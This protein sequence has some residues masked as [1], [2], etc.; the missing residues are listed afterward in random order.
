VAAVIVEPVVGNM[1]TVAPAP[2][3]LQ[4][5]RDL[6]AAAGS[7][8]IFDEVIT[9]FRT[10][11]GGAQRRFGV[12]PDLT[13][14]GKIV[15]GGLP[16]AAVAGPRVIMERLAPIGG[17]YQ[18]G[19][20]SGNPL[21]VAAGIATL[22]E[23]ENGW[24]YAR[25]EGLGARLEERLRPALS[26]LPRPVCLNRVGSMFTLFFGVPAVDRFADAV[27]SD[28]AAYARFF[29]AMLGRGVY[30][31]PAQ[32]EACFISL[33]HTED[34]IDQMVTAARG[35]LEGSFRDGVLPGRHG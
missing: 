14:L 5:L 21:A 28:A 29:H 34:D 30:L 10:A 15:G 18:G 13:C 35:A 11:W 17:V 8:L 9:G 27:R 26:G 32:F 2:G 31:P 7:L 6:T 23:M 12:T 33:A 1:G 20:L 24:Q 22:R 3:F 25:L 4:R 16:L 19:T